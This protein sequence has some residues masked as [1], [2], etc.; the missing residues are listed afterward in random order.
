MKGSKPFPP[1]REVGSCDFP[2]DYM[3][4]CQ[5]CVTTFHIHLNVGIFLFAQYVGVAQLLSGYLSKGIAPCIAVE[6]IFLWAEVNSG[7]SYVAILN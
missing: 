4:L 2:S 1:Q 6:S 5:E 3:S 7:S